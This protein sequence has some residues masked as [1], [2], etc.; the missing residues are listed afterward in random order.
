M[1]RGLSTLAL[2]GRPERFACSGRPPMFPERLN[3]TEGQREGSASQRLRRLL[4]RIP[5]IVP[6]SHGDRIHTLDTTGDTDV[7]LVGISA[8]SKRRS[9]DLTMPQRVLTAIAV[10][11]PRTPQVGSF[12]NDIS[13]RPRSRRR[14]RDLD[15]PEF[16]QASAELTREKSLWPAWR[17]H[18]SRNSYIPSHG[19]CRE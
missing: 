16:A 10:R 7:A 15:L 11:Q 4:H 14:D 1:T 17:K 8:Q 6:V 13:A 3:A 12:H 5:D 9:G 2:G 18:C 19:F